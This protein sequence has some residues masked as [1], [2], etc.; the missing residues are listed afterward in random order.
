MARAIERLSARQVEKAN[1]SGYYHDGGGLYLQ[2]GDTLTK[3]WIFR[4][5]L[6]GKTR[7]MGLGSFNTFSLAEARER[8]KAQ[9]QLLADGK[10]PIE[11]RKAALEVAALE[12][13]KSQ[14][15]TFK[16]CADKYIAAQRSGWKN[17]KHAGQWTNTLQTYALPVVGGL[18][19]RDIDTAHIKRILEPIWT[20]KTETA[21]RVR[22]RIEAVLN[23]AAHNGYR[24]EG[25]N[26]ARWKGHLQF[27]FAKRS[28]V[29]K[30]ENFPALP[31]QQAGVFIQE[32]RQLPG[33]AARALEFTILTA[34]RTGMTLGAKPEEFNLEQGVWTV[35]GDRMKAGKEHRVPLSRRAVEIIKAQP[36]GDYIFAGRFKGASLSN[37]AMLEV[38]RGMGRKDL[39]V[40]GFRSTFRDWAAEQTSYPHEMQEIALAHI[41]DDK[42]VAAYLRTDMMEKRRRLMEDWAG[43][44]NA[45][46]AAADVT[47]IRKSA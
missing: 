38:V 39:T 29:R 31:Y 23:W 40:H 21:T 20:T 35:P 13:S 3:S 42:T 46:K 6:S 18:S 28:K 9:R 11:I 45:P 27:S 25:P 7:E 32:L 47:P 30:A 10:D 37:M 16:E 8:A 12:S 34:A 5:T 15:L 24:D 2:V 41:Q 17:A 33:N 1:K 4:Y 19:V 43:Y 36:E 14:T 26:P 44:C 22:S